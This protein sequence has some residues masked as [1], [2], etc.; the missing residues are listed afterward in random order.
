[1]LHSD[2]LPVAAADPGRYWII[3]GGELDREGTGAIEATDCGKVIWFVQEGSAVPSVAGRPQDLTLAGP[4]FVTDAGPHRTV[5]MSNY[6]FVSGESACSSSH[7]RQIVRR[8][9]GLGGAQP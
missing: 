9:D 6:S 8:A 2:P 1:V 5:T 3:R 7:K 4:A